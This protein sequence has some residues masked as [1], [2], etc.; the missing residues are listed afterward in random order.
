MSNQGDAACFKCDAI[1]AINLIK[2]G[3]DSATA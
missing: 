2:N 3:V 1:E